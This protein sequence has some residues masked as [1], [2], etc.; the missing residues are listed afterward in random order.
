[1]LKWKDCGCD[2]SDTT[3][4]ILH[5]SCVC[6][7][8]KFKDGTKL[9]MIYL[10]VPNADSKEVI[11]LTKIRGCLSDAKQKA[12]E[13]FSSFNILKE[14]VDKLK[15]ESTTIDLG[16]GTGSYEYVAVEDIDFIL[17]SFTED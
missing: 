9:Y 4:G 5:I 11:T 2:D 12:E 17:N 13:L 15:E 14:F 10:S 1:M 6:S 3:L 16:C 7:N 8:R